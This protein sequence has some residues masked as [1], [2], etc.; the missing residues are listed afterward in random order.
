MM[1]RGR[2]LL[3][4]AMILALLISTLEMHAQQASAKGDRYFD[5]NQFDEA[6][7]F[8]KKDS[9]SRNRK[10]KEHATQRLADCYRITGNF[11]K[12]E[13]IYKKILGRSRK[14]PLA[15]LNYGISLMNSARYPEASAM[16][17]EYLVLVPGDKM[18]TVYL[19]SCD[20]AQKWLDETLGREVRNV[21]EINTENS[22]FA[23]VTVEGGLVFLSA[24]KGSTRKLISFD[25]GGDIRRLDFYTIGVTDILGNKKLEPV[26]EL[27]TF[28][29]E[30]PACYSADGSE[31]YFTKTVKGTRDDY[32]NE[33]I[34][35]LQVFYRSKD[36]NGAWSEPKSAF[37]FNSLEFSVGHPALTPDGNRI[38]FMSDMPGGFGKTDIYYSQKQPD[39]TWGKPR[40]AGDR[41]N[42][43]AY[44][45]FP[46]ISEEGDLYFASNGHPGM[47]QLDIFR[48]TMNEGAF[49]HPR[50]MRPPVN[51]IS[52]DFGISFYGSSE[53]GFI[54]S[55]RF[56]GKGAEDIYAF[57]DEKPLE[58]RLAESTII[59]NDYK[60]FDNITYELIDSAGTTE[61]PLN[62]VDGKLIATIDEKGTYIVEAKQYGMVINRVYLRF[63]KDWKEKAI[64][65]QVYSSDKAVRISGLNFL[66]LHHKS[67]KP[68]RDPKRTYS[69]LKGNRFAE[70]KMSIDKTG[71]FTF[72]VE[73]EPGTRNVISSLDV[74]EEKEKVGFSEE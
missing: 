60:L 37:S 9:R 54:S 25:G 17:R 29:H 30:G 34:N 13:E 16:F 41:V 26:K 11:V 23:P 48:S 66:G 52:N 71:V 10:V 5:Q 33:V 69:N 68:K 1:M 3:S 47:G 14:N 28:A 67:A 19:Q 12:A 36:K 40:N 49:S 22:E 58:I 39:G 20:S 55:D 63:I 45:L 61:I 59:L 64:S 31:M 24:R 27:N 6:I 44:E 8:Y 72:K 21:H 73:L 46:S 56:N 35:T 4:Y 50:N 2:Y 57:A 15:Y 51:S 42:T 70:L 18:G 38:Y 32:K 53:R 74:P 43:F 62:N 7:D 65:Y